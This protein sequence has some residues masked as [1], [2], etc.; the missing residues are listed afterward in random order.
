MKRLRIRPSEKDLKFHLS[1]SRTNH[2]VRSYLSLR[3]HLNRWKGGDALFYYPMHNRTSIRAC[4]E[5]SDL[6]K[7]KSTQF[8]NAKLMTLTPKRQKKDSYFLKWAPQKRHPLQSAN[9]ELRLRAL[10][11]Q[12]LKYTLLKL[13]LPRLL[14]PDFPFNWYSM[15]ILDCS[16]SD[17]DAHEVQLLVISCHYLAESAMGNLRACCLP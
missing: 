11:P 9:P 14:A 13:E 1:P 17:R 12:Q 16:H 15:S 4:F 5:H 7:V 3:R 8:P 6:F 2:A 10:Q